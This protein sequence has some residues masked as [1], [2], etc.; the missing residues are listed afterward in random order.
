[1][2]AFSSLANE[3]ADLAQYQINF[4]MI[5]SS[6]SDLTLSGGFTVD[7]SRTFSNFLITVG[8]TTFDLTSAANHP[9][10]SVGCAGEPGWLI[11]QTLK[12]SSMPLKYVVEYNAVYSGAPNEA[13]FSFMAL[14][15]SGENFG[16]L[17]AEI[18]DYVPSTTTGGSNGIG[19]WYT[20]P[21]SYPTADS[22]AV[23]EPGFALELGLVLGALIW[24]PKI[25]HQRL[26]KT[27]AAGKASESRVGTLL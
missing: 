7:A 13:S 12:C 6:P 8:N 23:P 20:T 26:G 18:V 2:L 27:R 3:L 17:E 15:A 22:V 21:A 10:A 11:F 14:G 4:Q 9:L 1:L 5:N 25:Y 24:S 19:T 16:V